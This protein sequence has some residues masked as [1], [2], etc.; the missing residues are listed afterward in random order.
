MV[1]VVNPRPPEP[2]LDL[3]MCV[4]PLHGTVRFQWIKEWIVTYKEELGA[5]HT[6]FYSYVRNLRERLVKVGVDS[7]VTLFSVLDMS[8]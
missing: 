4:P 3:S 8:I 1:E 5:E 6:S 2:A 7:R